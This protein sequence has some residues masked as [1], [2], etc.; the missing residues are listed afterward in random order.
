MGARNAPDELNVN[1]VLADAKHKI[2]E[3]MNTTAEELARREAELEPLR[4][5]LAELNDALAR[6]EGRSEPGTTRREAKELTDEE[7]ERRRQRR[8][9]RRAARKAREEAVPP[10]EHRP[11][12]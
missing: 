6:I 8:Q 12:P 11:T 1:A 3:A 5:R 9:E 10:N 4:A 7:R 2:T